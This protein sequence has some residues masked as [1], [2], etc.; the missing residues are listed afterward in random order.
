MHLWKKAEAA[1]GLPLRAIY[2]ESG[3]ENL[4]AETRSLQ[5]AITVVNLALWFYVCGRFDPVCA[6]ATAWANSA[7]WARPV[8]STWIA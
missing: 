3:D 2:W 6:A 4:M 5:P 8:C 1:S 7:R